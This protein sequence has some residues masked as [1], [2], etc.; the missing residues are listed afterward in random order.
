MDRQDYFSLRPVL[1]QKSHD[2]SSSPP[3]THKIDALPAAIRR[4]SMPHVTPFAQ[5]CKMAPPSPRPRSH[6]SN[7]SNTTQNGSIQSE[8]QSILD[9]D[10]SSPIM[11]ASEG[12]AQLCLPPPKRTSFEK[13][14]SP[15]IRGHGTGFEIL[16]PGSLNPSMPKENPLE[17]QR[18]APPISLHNASRPRSCSA[19]SRRKL[20]KKRRQSDVS[21]ASS[22]ASRRSRTNLF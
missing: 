14:A 9:S 5:F 20:Q 18:A 21:T 7:S 8:S 19:D 1:S 2:P 12:A 6:E 16:R 17:R 13:R 3:S 11:P 4:A 10:P 15:V 22:N